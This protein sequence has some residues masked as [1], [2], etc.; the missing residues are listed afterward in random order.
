MWVALA[1]CGC[2][3]EAIDIRLAARDVG[4]SVEQRS[5]VP[6]VVGCGLASVAGGT[7]TMGDVRAY[8]VRGA[9]LRAEPLQPGITMS[10]F[11]LDRYEV[12][13]A[14]FRRFVAERMST[15]GFD[16]R[17]RNVNCNW[18]TG[19]GDREDHPM[20]CVDWQAA[21]DFCR[22]D[23]VGGTLPSEAQWEFTARGP[24]YRPWP[25]IGADSDAPDGRVC[26]SRAVPVALGT[27]PEEDAT[28]A[29]GS[30]P[31]GVWQLVGNVWEWASDW[32]APYTDAACWNARSRNDPVCQNSG[33]G[34]RSMRG[35][36]WYSND[37]SVL[38][39]SA[40]SAYPGSTRLTFVGFRCASPA[41]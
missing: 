41:R 11:L 27:C 16:D 2:S 40:R 13:V 36:A 20:N 18:T 28:Y 25:W 37:T 35:G 33:S 24:A 22:W 8:D 14:R 9:G 23:T 6:R 1:A 39:S 5:C 30:T 19:P 38:R 3:F 17:T 12:T 15:A 7:F 29:A 32:Y 34:Y 10:A 31:E 26:W 21:M 4:A